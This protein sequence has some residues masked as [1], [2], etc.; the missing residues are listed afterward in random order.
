MKKSKA[1]LYKTSIDLTPEARDI[2]I[3]Y[4]ET[5]Q[6]NI[7][8]RINELILTFGNLSPE[9]H[10]DLTEF[11]E[12]KVK[13]IC[14]RKRNSDGFTA[15]ALN[16]ELKSYLN[17]I[18]FLNDGYQVYAE[19]YMDTPPLTSMPI[20]HG[21]VIYPADWI[22]VNPEMASSCP[23]VGVIECAHHAELHIPHFMFH[24]EYKYGKDYTDLFTKKVYKKCEEVW[25][26]FS[27]IIE[28]QVRAV[29]DPQN[30]SHMLNEKEWLEAPLIGMFH[31]YVEGD[32]RSTP[33][34]YGAKIVHTS[35][36]EE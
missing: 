23:Y 3:N 33:P 17:V 31:L 35:P 15:D 18:T 36:V 21:Y 29:Y 12:N 24:T 10:R 28:Q 27:R 16:E 20:K 32:Y 25:P 22:D 19:N 34:P 2:L 8:A 26:E 4:K 1:D 6:Q 9:T 7:G 11:F 30:P 5:H 13:D 14:W